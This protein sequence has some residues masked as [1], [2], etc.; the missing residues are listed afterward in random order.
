[1]VDA[2]SCGVA[3][4]H[5]QVLER[6]RQLT[7]WQEAQQERL[8]AVQQEQI[9]RLRGD[10]SPGQQ[11]VWGEG[12]QQ[13][14]GVSGVGEREGEGE[15]GG[16][17]GSVDSGLE[18]GGGRESE[19]E[20]YHPH[21]KPQPQSLLLVGSVADSSEDRPIEPGVCEFEIRECVRVTRM[22]VQVKETHLRICWR[23]N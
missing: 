8:R 6:L 23:G 12:V 9:A 15:G 1:M 2:M 17:R 14:V 20:P 7:V 13:E 10:L 19:D 4:E 21:P 22:C 16:G 18:T 3:A 5:Q 11:P